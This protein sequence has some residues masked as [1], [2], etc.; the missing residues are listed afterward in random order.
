M[1]RAVK[2]RVIPLSR[3]RFVDL[4]ARALKADDLALARDVYNACPYEETI[5]TVDAFAVAA[6]HASIPMLAWLKRAGCPFHV[7]VCEAAAAAG[8]MDNLVWLRLETTFSNAPKSSKS[9]TCWADKYRCPWDEQTCAAAAQGGHL[10]V[11]KW[12]REHGCPWD[13]DAIMRSVNSYHIREWV[14]TQ[15]N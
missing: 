14:Y 9:L 5:L 11:L 12:A 7:V 1:P 2:K 3:D 6:G 4:F 13:R 8:N 10:T 15:Q